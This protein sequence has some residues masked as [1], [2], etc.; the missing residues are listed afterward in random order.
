MCLKM[1]KIFFQSGSILCSIAQE[2]GWTERYFF[3]I[4]IIFFA[5]REIVFHI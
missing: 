2:G 5:N 1:K 3:Q 4:G